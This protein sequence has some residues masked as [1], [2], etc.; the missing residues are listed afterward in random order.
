LFS[1]P[2]KCKHSSVALVAAFFRAEIALVFQRGSDK[3]NA[4]NKKKFFAD[5]AGAASERALAKG[6]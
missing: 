4:V 6:S 3:F 5:V 2:D 1:A